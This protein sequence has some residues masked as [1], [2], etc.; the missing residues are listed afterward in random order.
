MKGLSILIPVGGEIETDPWRA[1]ALDWLLRRYAAILPDAEL[2]FGFSDHE[3][4]NRS[5]ARN[6]AFSKSTGE[7]LLV[8][9]ADTVLNLSQITKAI[10]LVREGLA[11]W[12]YPYTTY[13]NL[14]QKAT[15]YLVEDAPPDAVIP[16]PDDEEAWE[17]RID[18]SPGGARLL[19]RDA[20]EMVGGF[21][22]HFTDW[23]YED[24]AFECA[25]DRRIG[26]HRR[27]AGAALHLWHD[28]GLNFNQPHIAENRARMR[29]YQ[30]GQLP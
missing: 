20:W 1:N 15:V 27:V 26:P 17:H 6:D 7:L 23:G 16:E 18:N 22:E 3:P 28:P 30:R 11:P 4:F 5:A 12:A 2:C 14:S 29:L 8:A 19:D 13:Y 25:M 21:D 9:D 10:M 24:T